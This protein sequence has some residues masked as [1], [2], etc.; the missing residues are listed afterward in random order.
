MCLVISKF[1]TSLFE[2]SSWLIWP[3][4]YSFYPNIKAF[5]PKL[6]N[7]SSLIVYKY[8]TKS[9]LENTFLTYPFTVYLKI[10]LYL[11]MFFEK[12]V[13][14]A[15]NVIFYKM[16]WGNYKVGLRGSDGLSNK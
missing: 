1:Y 8:K 3:S 5:L 12:W 4:S 14:P 6:Q 9:P 11:S 7:S 15:I 2:W 10:S 13:A 16:S